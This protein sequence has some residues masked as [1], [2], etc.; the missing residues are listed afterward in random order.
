[1]L[2]QFTVS[3]EKRYHWYQLIIPREEYSVTSNADE[4]GIGRRQ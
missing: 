3:P 1:M 4:S 2:S